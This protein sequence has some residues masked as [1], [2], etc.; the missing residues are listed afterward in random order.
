MRGHAEVGGALEDVQV[1]R[2]PGQ[3]RDQLDPGRAG[4]DDADALAG[5]LD[6]VLGPARG[7]VPLALELVEALER[8]A[9]HRRQASRGHHAVPRR[10]PRRRHSVAIRQRR[11]RVVVHGL[12]RPACPAGCRGGG[13]TDPRRGSGSA[14]A[15]VPLGTARSIPIPARAPPRTSTSS[16]PTRCRSE[17]RGSGSSTRCRPRRRPARTRAR[18]GPGRGGGAAHRAR[19]SLRRRRSRRTP[20]ALRRPADRRAPAARPFMLAWS[21]MCQSV[22]SRADES[23]R[24]ALGAERAGRLVGRV[25]SRPCPRA[26]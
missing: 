3:L 5:E 4:A 7:V 25:C 15:P 23:G 1:L 19:R 14:G 8:R 13:R 10:V 17:R 20:A 18:S 9:V 22:R 21:S 16:R 2:L 6:P 24:P 26:S 11:R 12:A